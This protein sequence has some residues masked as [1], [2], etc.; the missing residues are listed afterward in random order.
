[1]TIFSSIMAFKML[2][3]SLLYRLLD[4]FGGMMLI[5]QRF[6]HLQNIKNG[7]L[8]EPIEDFWRIAAS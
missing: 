2:D 4:F 8:S 3:L 1:M 7:I 5:G 6:Q